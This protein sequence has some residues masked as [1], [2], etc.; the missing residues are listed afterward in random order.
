MS[1]TS[2]TVNVPVNVTATLHD[3]NDDPLANALV[4]VTATNVGSNG[5]VLIDGDPSSA[6]TNGSA[7]ETVS[8]DASGVAQFSVSGSA[9][10]SIDL[11]VDY[12]AQSIDKATIQVTAGGQRDDEG[13]RPRD[14]REVVGVRGRLRPRGAR[15]VLQRRRG[16]HVV[17]VLDLRR[18]EVDRAL[19]RRDVDH[20]EDPGQGQVLSRHRAR[21]QRQRG[22]RGVGG[23]GDRHA[24]VIR[25]A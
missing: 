18:I 22:R 5:Q 7:S 3:T 9:P 17:P 8:T 1:A 11:T 24:K 21:A 2:A 4:S 16:D 15:A 13:P 19:A 6:T 14:D 23:E 12:E 10:G 20:R 25:T